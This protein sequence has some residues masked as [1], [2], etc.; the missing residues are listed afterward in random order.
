MKNNKK[1]STLQYLSLIT[2]LGISSITPI[3]LGVLLGQYLD[4]KIGTQG[5]F[6][7]ILLI[8]GALTAINN[9][10][11]LASPKDKSEEDNQKKE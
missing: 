3:I 2:Q 9:I 8:L 5:V 7:I 4:K 10:Y 6:S 1:K 11:R